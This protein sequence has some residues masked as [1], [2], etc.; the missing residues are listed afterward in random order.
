MVPLFPALIKGLDVMDLSRRLV[1]PNHTYIPNDA[2]KAVYERN[3]KVF[4]K[5]YRANAAGFAAING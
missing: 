3:Y 4:R 2:N 1:R 5:L